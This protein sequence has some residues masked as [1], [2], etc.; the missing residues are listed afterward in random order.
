M[1]NCSKQDMKNPKP[2]LN[3]PDFPLYDHS[4]MSALIE[5]ST[6]SEISPKKTTFGKS[7]LLKMRHK[8]CDILMRHKKKKTVRFFFKLRLMST[9]HV[10]VATMLSGIHQHF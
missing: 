6:L 2:D 7:R 9:Y 3:S 5:I 1:R 4:E 10:E 8:N